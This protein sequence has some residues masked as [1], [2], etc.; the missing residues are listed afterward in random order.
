M[1][2]KTKEPLAII[3]GTNIAAKRKRKGMNQAQFAEQL[4]IGADS[5]SRIESGITAPKFQNLAKIAQVLECTVAELFMCSGDG[6]GVDFSKKF[7]EPESAMSEIVIMAEKII[8]VAKSQG[9]R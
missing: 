1:S 3:V 9:K 2:R 8:K 4:G 6:S 7:S 5:L